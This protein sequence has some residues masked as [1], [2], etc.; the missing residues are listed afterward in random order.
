MCCFL[1]HPF[2]KGL[3]LGIPAAAEDFAWNFGNIMLIR[4]LNSISATAAGVYTIV[5]GIEVIP[6]CVFA[7]LGQATLTLAGRETGKGDLQ[8]MRKIVITSFL[9]SME[10][11]TFFL[12]LF[13]AIPKP[14]MSMFTQDQTIIASAAIYLAIVSINLYPKSG[15]IIIGSGIRG[16]GN[17]KWMLGT[18]LFGTVFIA[19]I[20]VLLYKL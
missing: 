13:M 20:L 3:K 11:A 8:Q 10:L 5:F 6:V 4:I 12:V 19:S 18:Q 17:T 14:I 7:A 1:Y 15:N 2:F 16:Y 9:W